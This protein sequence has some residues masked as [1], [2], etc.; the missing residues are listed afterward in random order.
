M[1][2]GNPHNAQ[3]PLTA[4]NASCAE[5]IRAGDASEFARLFNKYYDQLYQFAGSYVRN[6]QAAENIVQDVFVNVWR[7][8]ENLI[9]ATV[10]AYLYTS[11]RNKSLNYLRDS[12]SDSAARG[13]PEEK[14]DTGRPVDEELAVL[15][16]EAAAAAAIADLPERCRAVFVLSRFDGLTYREI[17]ERLKISVKTVESQ[18]GIALKKLR[19]RLSP[20]LSV[21]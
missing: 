9:P 20:F 7:Q 17:A 16:F 4:S 21:L 5:K 2:D 6:S 12:R 10:K 14:H 8:R 3:S 13:S 18:M 15:E 1:N 11:V 19:S